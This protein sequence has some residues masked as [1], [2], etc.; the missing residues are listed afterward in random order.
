MKSK[1]A[2]G[3]LYLLLK[4][5]SLFFRL[6]KNFRK[7]IKDFKGRY[8]FKSKDG[9][10]R[11]SVIFKKGKDGKQDIMKVY[12]KE[13]ENSNVAVIFKDASAMKNFLLSKHPDILNSVLKQDI[14]IDGNL[15]YIYKFGYM[16]VHMGKI[17][18]DGFKRK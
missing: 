7:N 6:A 8:I 14:T 18:K 9:S 3:F 17:I 5:M 16:A 10:I 15:T 4:A 2:E 13:I 11:V 1:I 12:K